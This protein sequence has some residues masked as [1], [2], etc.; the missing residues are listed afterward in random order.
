MSEVKKITQLIKESLKIV[1]DGGRYDAFAQDKVTGN[2]DR[3][4]DELTMLESSF[5]KLKG[6]EK[7]CVEHRHSD[8][9]LSYYRLLSPKG[10]S[11]HLGTCE[12]SAD[13]FIAEANTAL[14][15][16]Q[17]QAEE[18]QKIRR[19]LKYIEETEYGLLGIVMTDKSHDGIKV[20]SVVNERA[21]KLEATVKQQAERIAELLS[22]LFRLRNNAK[23]IFDKTPVRDW[24]ETLVEADAALSK[25]QE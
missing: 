23:R 6:E 3:A 17:K 2:L 7:F 14:A 22:A 8:Y 10:I 11:V 4:L 21:D 12:D 16:V 20:T 25:E 5:V 24:A 18:I 13:G 9:H 1:L 15:I 19:R